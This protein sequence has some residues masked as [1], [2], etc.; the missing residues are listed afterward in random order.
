MGIGARAL[1][2]DHP[3]LVDAN[4]AD[5]IAVFAM[6]ARDVR[7]ATPAGAIVGRDLFVT[8]I[9]IWRIGKNAAG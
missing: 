1:S 8:G 9:D 3:R 4:K 6:H 7:Q 5:V 2:V